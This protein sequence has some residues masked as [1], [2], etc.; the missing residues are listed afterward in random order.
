MPLGLGLASSHAPSM[1]LAVEKWDTFYQKLVRDVP[2][3]AEA[4]EETIDVIHRHLARIEENFRMLTEQLENYRPEA[5]VIVGD[6]QG[7]VFSDALVPLM[8]MYLGESISGTTNLEA[9][10][11]RLEE[12]HIEFKCHQELSK[13]LLHELV[14]SGFDVAYSKELV[15]MGK[16]KGGL[17]HAFTRPGKALRL[18]QLGIPIIPIFLSA[19]HPP[20]PSAQRCLDLGRAIRRIFD[21]V[22]ARIAIYGSGGLS[23]DPRGP[24]AGWVDQLLDRWVLDQI[25]SGNNANLVNLFTVESDT[26]RGGTGEIRS[27][28]TVAG[29]FEKTRATVVDYFPAYHAVTG[30]GFAYWRE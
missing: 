24:R 30:I 14:N 17:G 27:W 7:E 15:P 19:Y 25:E 1:F 8:A 16:P 10:G 13:L 5:L 28:V 23:H 2:Q 29:A 6:D 11:E 22:P 3:P 26:L 9:L 21:K 4:K 18:N 12:N 20:L